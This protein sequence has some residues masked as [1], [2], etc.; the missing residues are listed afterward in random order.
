MALFFPY[1]VLQFLSP[2]TFL[3]HPSLPFTFSCPSL[4]SISQIFV[5]CP[6]TAIQTEE[7]GRRG[8]SLTDSLMVAGV[9]LQKEAWPWDKGHSQS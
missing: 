9:R 8:Q 6:Q 4:F 7:V 1:C 5:F 3:P 2:L